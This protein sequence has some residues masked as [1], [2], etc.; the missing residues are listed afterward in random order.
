MSTTHFI[1]QP[2]ARPIPESI[3]GN[4]DAALASNAKRPVLLGDSMAVRHLRSQIQRIAPYFRIAIIRGEGGAGKQVVARAIH[5]RSAGAHGPFIVADAAA[6]ADALHAGGHTRS[7][8]SLVDAAEGGTLYLLRVAQLSIVQQDSLMGFFRDRD[9]RRAAPGG[10]VQRK[11]ERR[12][13]TPLSARNCDM[14]I[15]VASDCDLRTLSAVGR[16][17]QDLYAQLSAVEIVIPPL[18]ERL[19]DIPVLATWLL[20][21]LAEQAGET[22]NHFSQ[23]G[24]AHLQERQWPSNLRELEKVDAQ[25]AALAEG[26][27]IEPCHLLALGKPATIAPA[28]ATAPRI[29]RLDEVVRRHVLDVL[30]RCGGNKLRAAELLGISRS[31]LYRML[32]SNPDAMAVYQR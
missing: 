20:R 21:R 5:A 14:R 30:T 1:Q 13:A 16:F 28:P 17:R 6:F 10:D 8:E 24:L 29:D 4:S 19:D 25:S 27:L 12:D 26:K 2:I 23:A 7:A 3:A 32:D 22:S 9:E 15:L 18:R 11:L 31:T